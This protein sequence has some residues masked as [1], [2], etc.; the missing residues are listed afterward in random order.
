MTARQILVSGAFAF[1]LL[2]APAAL[3]APVQY[4]DI[5]GLPAHARAFMAEEMTTGRVPGEKP[6]H[7]PTVVIHRHHHPHPLLRRKPHSTTGEHWP[8]SPNSH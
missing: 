3:A 2:A 7:H 5:S 4:D 1:G 8:A 6:N